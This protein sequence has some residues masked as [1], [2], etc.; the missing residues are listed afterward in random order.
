VWLLAKGGGRAEWMPKMGEYT[1]RPVLLTLGKHRDF[2]K[3]AG[4]SR[5]TWYDRWAAAAL[6]RQTL[7]AK[8]MAADLYHAAFDALVT[9]GV[10]VRT[11]HH[12]G[13][14]LA[15]NPDALQVDTEVAFVATAGNKRR[16]A[17]PRQDAEFLLDMPCLDAVESEYEQLIPEAADWWSR[18][19]SHG[20]LRR[21]IAAEHTGLLDRRSARRWSCASRTSTPSRGSRTCCPPR[22]RW[23]WAWTSATCR[24]CCCARCRRT[25][26]AFLQRM[27]R[28][29]PP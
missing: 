4:N 29:G 14:T 22:P 3:L 28:A 1:P 26:P 8:G 16:L 10:L 9:A 18:R 12:L 20:D 5:P 21:V 6:G 19:F 15:L 11:V 24:R 17:V 25:R 23:K 13:D 7:L 2:D 27:G